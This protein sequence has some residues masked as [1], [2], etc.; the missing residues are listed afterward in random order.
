MQWDHFAVPYRRQIRER[1]HFLIHAHIGG[2]QGELDAFDE[3]LMGKEDN[4]LLK[5]S[6]T[7]KNLMEAFAGLP[8]PIISGVRVASIP[9]VLPN[10]SSSP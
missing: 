5:G 2:A 8:V 4:M 6:K 10:E 7:E 3:L 1:A 9:V